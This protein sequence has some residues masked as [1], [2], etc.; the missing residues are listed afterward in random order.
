MC[1]TC[2]C[3]GTEI[4]KQTMTVEGMSCNHCKNAVEKAARA[5]PGVLAAEVDLA[6]NQLTVEYNPG[7]SNL[8]EIKTAVEEAGY[9]VV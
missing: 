2:G 3:Q 7:K 9:T 5:L 1:K 4:T 6:A 8:E